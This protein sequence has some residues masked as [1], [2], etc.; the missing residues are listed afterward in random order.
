ML[1]ITWSIF[2]Y[3]IIFMG[4][5]NQNKIKKDVKNVFQNFSKNLLDLRI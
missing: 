2:K 3:E 1:N 5:Y 4:D